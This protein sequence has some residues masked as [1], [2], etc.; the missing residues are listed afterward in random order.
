MLPFFAGERD[1]DQRDE[2]DVEG[3]VI[4]FYIGRYPYT[5]SPPLSTPRA[6]K[7]ILRRRSHGNS[8]KEHAHKY[9]LWLNMSRR[10][11]EGEQRETGGCCP[12]FKKET[13]YRQGRTWSLPSISFALEGEFRHWL[14][15][16]LW[17]HSHSYFCIFIINIFRQSKTQT[18]LRE[19]K[20]DNT[21]YVTH[22]KLFF[23]SRLDSLEN[24]KPST[25]PA[26]DLN[27]LCKT[28]SC[29]GFYF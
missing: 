15:C 4:R 24:D 6:T 7:G 21:C 14:Q 19:L 16:P 11:N 2:E 12:P 25:K 8:C 28:N 5:P 3:D 10:L 27:A 9:L 18:L 22:W 26:G 29:C 23:P 1:D 13:K 20:K 17:S